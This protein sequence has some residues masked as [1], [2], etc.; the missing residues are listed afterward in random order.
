MQKLL[1]SLAILPLAACGVEGGDT[2]AL[3]ESEAASRPAASTVDFGNDNGSWA[4]DGEC[5]DPRF[6]GPGM[7]TTPLLDE[8]IKADATDCRTAYERGDLT[9]IE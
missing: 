3:T 8:D 9:L 4:N 1:L 5:D 7:T 2:T 6:K